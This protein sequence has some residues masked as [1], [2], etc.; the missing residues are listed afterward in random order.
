MR[1]MVSPNIYAIKP[2]QQA[3]QVV[4][5]ETFLR[6]TVTYHSNAYYIICCFVQDRFNFPGRPGE[7]LL[8]QYGTM[9]G[10]PT[11]MAYEGTWNEESGQFQVRQAVFQTRDTT[12]LS[13]GGRHSWQMNEAASK[14]AE[15]LCPPANWQGDLGCVTKNVMR[16]GV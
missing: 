16:S 6:I 2:V 10:H 8:L 12:V 9:D 1:R 11:W 7:K 14:A 15:P 5:S 3:G 4:N 13:E